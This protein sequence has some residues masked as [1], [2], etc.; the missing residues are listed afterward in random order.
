MNYPNYV[1]SI[2]LSYSIIL[3][4]WPTNIP[5]T[6][7]WN[8]HTVAE[9]REL[10]DALKGAG[11]TIGK[12]CKKHSDSGTSRK[13][14]K[15]QQQDSEDEHPTKKSR[16]SNKTSKTSRVQPKSRKIIESSDEEVSVDGE[17]L[18]EDE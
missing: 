14:K 12:P 1:K 9:I 11:E 15:A 3:D 4:G 7:P 6:S 18:D 16:R 10:R 2:V 5:F 13:R 8:I 17:G